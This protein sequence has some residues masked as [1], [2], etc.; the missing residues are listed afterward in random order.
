MFCVG[1]EQKENT[2]SRQSSVDILSELDEL[3]PP[4]TLTKAATTS[5]AA[6]T[7][8]LQPRVMTASDLAEQ[9]RTARASEEI[10]RASADD[11]YANPAN[12]ARL[13]A[14]YERLQELVDSF[15]GDKTR[16]VR[17]TCQ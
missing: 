8:T 13:A 6:S 7:P 1:V 10:A 3:P 15:A 17:H 12:L 14:E 4:A 11:P 5:E 9:Q 16:Q 2:A